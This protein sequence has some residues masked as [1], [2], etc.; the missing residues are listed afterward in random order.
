MEEYP[1]I[2]FPPSQDQ[3][4]REDFNSSPHRKIGIYPDDHPSTPHVELDMRLTANDSPP[5]T[6]TSLSPGPVSED[7]NDDC[8]SSGSRCAFFK[9]KLTREL[10]KADFDDEMRRDA[11]A[12]L[13][14]SGLRES[15][16]EYRAYRREYFY[17]TM[18]HWAADSVPDPGLEM[19]DHFIEGHD[20]MY[21]LH[22]N[23]LG[24]IQDYLRKATSY[25][26][27][28]AYCGLPQLAF[29]VTYFGK[30]KLEGEFDLDLLPNSG[31]KLLFWAFLRHELMS[32]IRL[33]KSM[34][35]PEY[36]PPPQLTQRRG[37]WFHPYEDEAIR[38]VQTYVS[39]L[40]E[41]F[42][43][44]WY[45][46]ELPG[47]VTASSSSR[48]S[49]P[50]PGQ[51]RR[52]VHMGFDIVRM[53]N[54]FS[55]VEDIPYVDVQGLSNFGLSLITRLMVD[56]RCEDSLKLIRRFTKDLKYRCDYSSVHTRHTAR[57]WVR[58]ERVPELWLD[59]C[60]R[61]GDAS[62]WSEE[63]LQLVRQRAWVF[64]PDSRL[65]PQCQSLVH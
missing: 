22:Q 39:S 9:S 8:L 28:R 32:E 42:F 41:A 49:S 19:D 48:D 15:K 37:R 11:L 7:G 55:L 64:F 1:L 62:A 51:L 10:I 35:H 58:D 54:T 13:R 18:N 47:L 60:L 4:S 26:L 63:A 50:P 27:P 46:V 65:H 16:N 40:Y 45:G 5:P 57:I 17:G 6:G 2:Q 34:F 31:R 33:Y 61:H 23:M 21:Q 44:E 59:I 53:K 29:E 12:I 30:Q 43:S 14:L 3:M 24:F 36:T 20:D 56:R 38:C 25:F 52:H